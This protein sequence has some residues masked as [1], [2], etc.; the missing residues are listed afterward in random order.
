MQDR[1]EKNDEDDVLGMSFFF[2]LPMKVQVTWYKLTDLRAAKRRDSTILAK[3][4][5]STF[6]FLNK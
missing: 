3:R 6:K 5:P 4:H 2:L 1:E